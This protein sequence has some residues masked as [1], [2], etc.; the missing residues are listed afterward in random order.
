L[1]HAALDA[2]FAVLGNEWAHLVPPSTATVSSTIAT[3]A[4]ASPSPF[5]SVA[6]RS[7]A[8]TAFSAWRRSTLHLL[9]W[10]GELRWCDKQPHHV[11]SAGRPVRSRRRVWLDDHQWLEQRSCRR[12]GRLLLLRPVTRCTSSAV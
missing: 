6:A 5:A 2:V 12:T 3:T 4:A 1:R 8:S 9:L 11:R 7:T 10:P